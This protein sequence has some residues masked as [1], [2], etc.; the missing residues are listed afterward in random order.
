MIFFVIFLLA[1]IPHLVRA[2]TSY[3]CA[4]YEPGVNHENDGSLQLNCAKAFSA[5]VLNGAGCDGMAWIPN[6]PLRGAYGDAGFP[7]C[8]AQV[9]SAT[10]KAVNTA[11]LLES[12]IELSARCWYGQWCYTDINVC[13]EIDPVWPS[14][15]RISDAHNISWA[16]DKKDTCVVAEKDTCAVEKKQITSKVPENATDAL[17]QA[18]HPIKV[19]EFC[20][21]NGKKP[22][23]VLTGPSCVAYTLV[24]TATAAYTHVPTLGESGEL[25]AAIWADVIKNVIAKKPSDSMLAQYVKIEDAN[26]KVVATIQAT[27]AI[28]PEAETWKSVYAELGAANLYNLIYEAMGYARDHEYTSSVWNIDKK[29]DATTILKLTVDAFKGKS[30]P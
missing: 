21:Y 13:G 5:A 23:S 11:Y 30:L 26:G 9:W 16:V 4:N 17:A 12:F 24:N 27:L 15:N 10:G 6:T 20:R 1:T 3:T 19:V 14:S 29:S 28:F 2:N 22:L 8:F 18:N 7:Y 25:M